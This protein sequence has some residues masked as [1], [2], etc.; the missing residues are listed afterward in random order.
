M[1]N[2]LFFLLLIAIVPGI[3]WGIA[4][5]AMNYHFEKECT[6]TFNVVSLEQ[7]VGHKSST[8]YLYRTDTGDYVM[9]E[10]LVTPP[11]TI[12]KYPKHVLTSNK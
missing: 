3:P 4:W 6:R 5:T 11:A 1:K 2:L 12:C 7:A 9:F 8:S 10:S